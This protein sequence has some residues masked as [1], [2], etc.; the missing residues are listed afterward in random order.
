M[1][2][3]ERKAS[4]WKKNKG[5]PPKNY[6]GPVD[7]IWTDDPEDTIILPNHTQYADSWV[8]ELDTVN[9]KYWRKA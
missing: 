5:H 1:K 2:K 8:L 4:G 7:T 6:K 9:I 3:A